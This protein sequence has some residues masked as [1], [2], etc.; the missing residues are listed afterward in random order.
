MIFKVVNK[1]LCIINSEADVIH[2]TENRYSLRM[3][4][5]KLFYRAGYS[6]LYCVICPS[7]TC[8]YVNFAINDLHLFIIWNIIITKGI[9]DKNIQ[10]YHH[11]HYKTLIIN[12]HNIHSLTTLLVT[13][14][15]YIMNYISNEFHNYGQLLKTPGYKP[16]VRLL[17]ELKVFISHHHTDQFIVKFQ[18]LAT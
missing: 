2:Y 7:S 9:K 5:H 1:T 17:W 8:V 18:I 16:Y 3:L 13:K 12:V 4:C 10:I 11:N 6:Y 14:L 15:P